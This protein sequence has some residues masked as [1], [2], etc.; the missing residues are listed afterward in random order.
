MKARAF[1]IGFVVI[2]FW[3]APS[4]NQSQARMP[5]RD[6]A[7]TISPTTQPDLAK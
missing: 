6:L 5:H 3:L 1:L 2:L 7:R 4:P